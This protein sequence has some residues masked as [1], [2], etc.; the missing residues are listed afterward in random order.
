MLRALHTDRKK[1][2]SEGYLSKSIKSDFLCSELA[3]FFFY[4]IENGLPK[5]NLSG[6]EEPIILGEMAILGAKIGQNWR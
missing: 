4:S 2:C 3:S 1:S 5:K 6:F